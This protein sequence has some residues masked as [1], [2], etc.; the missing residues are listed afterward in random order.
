MA[1]VTFVFSVRDA[2][3]TPPGARKTA[4]SPTWVFF[5]KLSDGSNLSQPSIIEIAQGQYKFSYDVATN[6][7]ASGQIDAG[8]S[9]TN[10]SDR[11]ID[12]ICASVDDIATGVWSASLTEPSNDTAARTT[13]G[14]RL[15]N[16]FSRF[17]NRVVVSNGLQTVYKDDSATAAATMVVND[18]GVT[19]TKGK[20]S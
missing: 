2:T 15:Y 8:S 9:L 16:L 4:L 18:D 19:E 13:T 3:S 5:K 14:G 1:L 12:I 7:E 17:Y 20:S 11:Y 6:G 10:A